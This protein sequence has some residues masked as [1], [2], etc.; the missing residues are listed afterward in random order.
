VASDYSITLSA[1]QAFA[2][3]SK[4]ST[5][6]EIAPLTTTEYMLLYYDGDSKTYTGPLSATLANVVIPAGSTVAT[7]VTFTLSN[8]S[9]LTSSMLN[10]YFATTTL[11]NNTVAI[12]YTDA[13]QNNAVVV[14]TVEVFRV[15]NNEIVFGSKLTVNSGASYTQLQTGLMDLDIVTVSENQEFLVLYSDVSNHG[16]ITATLGQVCINNFTLFSCLFHLI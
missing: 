3:D 2:P 12:T 14:Q 9:T 6:F 4:N 10:Y 1:V 16:A 7:D 13:N 11:D 8:T 5:Y 15:N